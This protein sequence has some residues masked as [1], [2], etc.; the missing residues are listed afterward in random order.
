M[1]RQRRDGRYFTLSKVS[2]APNVTRPIG[3]RIAPVRCGS[4]VI[5][6]NIEAHINW[7]FKRQGRS[8]T[9]AGTEQLAQLL[10]LRSQPTAWKS[11]VAQNRSS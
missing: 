5:E 6:K 8:W 10:W 2:L 3:R 1:V 4:G 9:R 7:H 11:L